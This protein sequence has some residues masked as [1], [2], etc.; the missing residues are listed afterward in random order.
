M[1]LSSLL[2]RL[3]NV[4]EGSWQSKCRKEEDH[5]LRYGP[6]SP[7]GEFPCPVCCTGVGSNSIFCNSCKHWV[8]KKCSELKHLTKDPDYRCTL[9]LP[10]VWQT[11]EGGPSWTWQAGGG[12]FLLLPRRHALS[13]R[14]QWTFN[15]NTCENRLEVQGAATSSLFIPPLFQ[16]TWPSHSSCVQSAMLHASETW[17][18]TKPN[19]QLLQQNDRAMIRQICNVRLQDVVTTRSNERAWHWGSWPHSEGEKAPLVW[20]C[21]TLQWCSPAFHIQVEGKHAPG[22]P[23]MTWNSWQRGIAENGS[24]RLSTLMIEICG[25]LVWA[26]QLSGRGPTD[27]DVAQYLQVNQK[28]DYDDMTIVL[29]DTSVACCV[30]LFTQPEQKLT[31]HILNFLAH[32]SIS[33]GWAIVITLCPL[34]VVRRQQLVY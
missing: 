20:T 5:D 18:L 14:W 10:L 29:L 2:I 21:G 6:G 7:A 26:S 16:D 33:S 19:L 24:S 12:S 8:H 4:T 3:R 34:S 31:N 32:L 11:T 28:S 30:N 1:T 23:K 25:D 15:H 13:S 27:V 17:P 22:R 9:G